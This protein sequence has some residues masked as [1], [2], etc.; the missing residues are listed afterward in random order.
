MIPPNIFL[1]TV[2]SIFLITRCRCRR[3]IETVRGFSASFTRLWVSLFGFKA[4]PTSIYLI[5]GTFLIFMFCFNV[6]SRRRPCVCVYICVCRSGGVP[7]L[8]AR[9]PAGGVDQGG[10]RERRLL[11]DRDVAADVVHEPGVQGV[12]APVAVAR[13]RRPRPRQEGPAAQVRGVRQAR[14][15]PPG[16][17]LRRQLRLLPQIPQQ[18][19]LIH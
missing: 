11:P 19:L 16:P 13:V 7:A 2:K 4:L 17:L 5:F 1:R 15:W 3:N 12:R 10:G 6:P 9:A 8:P 14:Q 18:V